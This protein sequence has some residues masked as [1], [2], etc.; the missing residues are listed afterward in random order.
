MYSPTVT[1]EMCRYEPVSAIKSPPNDTYAVTSSAV[2]S[3]N[4]YTCES[5]RERVEEEEEEERSAL[6]ARRAR[7]GTGGEGSAPC[8]T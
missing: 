2:P 5:E 4:L 6:A 7:G 8:H 1:R 3:S